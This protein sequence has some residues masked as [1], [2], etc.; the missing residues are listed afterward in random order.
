MQPFSYK[1]A[2]DFPIRYELIKNFLLEFNNTMTMRT[3]RNE[4]IPYI[5][6]VF[7]NRNDM[8]HHNP[9]S[10][11]ASMTKV[12]SSYSSAQKFPFIVVR[13]IFPTSLCILF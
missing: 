11:A 9:I 4:V 3:K 10:P 12:V 6:P 1:D 7:S 2:D 5:F 8:M 13:T